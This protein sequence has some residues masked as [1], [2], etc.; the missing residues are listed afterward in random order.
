MAGFPLYSIAKERGCHGKNLIFDL[1][2]GIWVRVDWISM[3]WVRFDMDEDDV[4]WMIIAWMMMWRRK[5][6]GISNR[7]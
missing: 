4:E 7:A 1:G 2:V 6:L 3:V 5:M